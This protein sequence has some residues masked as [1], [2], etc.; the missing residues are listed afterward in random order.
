MNLLSET[1]AVQGINTPNKSLATI[2]RSTITAYYPEIDVYFYTL[3]LKPME[4]IYEHH[5]SH[6]DT[7]DDMNN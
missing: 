7:L 4:A 5:H 6:V 3:H 2:D 1:R